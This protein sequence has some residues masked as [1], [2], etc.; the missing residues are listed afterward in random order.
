[1]LQLACNIV[2]IGVVM[3]RNYNSCWLAVHGKNV[4]HG[5][6]TGVSLTV[7]DSFKFIQYQL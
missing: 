3:V 5:D 4:I 7:P 6:L 1:M 2:R